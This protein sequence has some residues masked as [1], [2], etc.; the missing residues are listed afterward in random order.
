MISIIRLV[1]IPHYRLGTQKVEKELRKGWGKQEN[2]SFSF[3]AAVLEIVS[4]AALKIG[5]Q[6]SFS[7]MIFSGYK[8]RGG[9]AR[10][11]TKFMCSVLRNVHTVFLGAAPTHYPPCPKCRRS[12]CSRRPLQH[13][14]CRS[15]GG[16]LSEG[17]S[18]YLVEALIDIPIRV[19]LSIFPCALLPSGCLLWKNVRLD[20]C[21]FSCWVDCFLF[22]FNLEL[23]QQ[24]ASLEMNS[25][26]FTSVANIYFPILWVVFFF[27]L[28]LPFLC[29]TFLG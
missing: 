20:L 24:F 10:S 12:A 3:P 8:A 18:W 5:V 27:P 25:L 22:F 14:T 21:L 16:W 7:V 23:C 17:V 11:G 26:F 19:V 15:L 9:L 6:P 2:F 4:S 29:K 28:G 1:L 13:L